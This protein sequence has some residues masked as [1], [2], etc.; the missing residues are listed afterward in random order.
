MTTPTTTGEAGKNIVKEFEDLELTA[1]PDPGSELGQKCAAL[2]LQMRDYKKVPG[3]QGMKG[4][5]WTIGWGHTGPEV[6]EGLTINLSHAEKLLA[7]DLLSA[8]R[9]VNR[10]TEAELNQNQ[11]DALVSFVFN[12]GVGNFSTSTLLKKLNDKDYAGAAKEFERWNKS[13]G[14]V[15]GGLTRRRKMEAELFSK[16][17]A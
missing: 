1:Y 11:F 9:S 5:P 17:V 6:H 3:W 13:K 10:Y 2:R 16:K 8:E 4:S 15:L 12:C 7:Q 14:K